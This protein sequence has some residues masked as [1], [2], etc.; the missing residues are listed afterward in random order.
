M[1]NLGCILFDKVLEE[2]NGSCENKA[3]DFWQSDWFLGGTKILRRSNK[4]A[5]G[6]WDDFLNIFDDYIWE[7]VV[8]DDLKKVYINVLKNTWVNVWRILKMMTLRVLLKRS[9]WKKEWLSIGTLSLFLWTYYFM[10]ER[11]LLVYPCTKSN[12]Q[13]LVVDFKKEQYS[14]RNTW[15]RSWGLFVR[16]DLDKVVW[17]SWLKARKEASLMIDRKDF[18]YQSLWYL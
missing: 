4:V 12:E 2:Y 1:K 8:N 13:Q 7:Q 3:L 15:Q 17:G 9:V 5:D 16:V 6:W 14:K 10:Q 18:V 11:V